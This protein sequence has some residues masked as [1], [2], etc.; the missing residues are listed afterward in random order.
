[1]TQREAPPR[2]GLEDRLSELKASRQ[3]CLYYAVTLTADITGKV[4][5]STQTQW[6][7]WS[8]EERREE[9]R[10]AR[11]VYPKFAELWSNLRQPYAFIHTEDEISLF[12]LAGGN[13]LIEQN[14]G[15]DIFPRLLGADRCV[16]DGEAGFVS[17]SLLEQTAFRRAPTPKIRMQILTRDRRRCRICGRNPDDYLDL[18]LH[19]HHI[20]PWEKGGITDPRNLITLCHTCHAGLEPHDDPSLFAYLRPKSN[21]PIEELLKEFHQGVSNYRRVGFF[22]NLSESSERKR[23]KNSQ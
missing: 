21:D 6:V 8:N 22:S 13:A 11:L 4:I 3:D 7:G 15:Q 2:P 5:F 14:L 18:V 17:A 1:M 10:R 9:L 23:Q 12:L 19:V 20:R 16:P